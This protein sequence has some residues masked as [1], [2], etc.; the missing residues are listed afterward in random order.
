[1]SM[2]ALI[3]KQQQGHHGAFNNN[4]QLQGVTTMHRAITTTAPT[5][6]PTRSECPIICEVYGKAMEIEVSNIIYPLVN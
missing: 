1:M 3:G 2:W 4:H 6:E 5:D